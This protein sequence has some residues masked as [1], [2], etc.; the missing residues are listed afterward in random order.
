[1]LLRSVSAIGLCD[2]LVGNLLPPLRL[3]RGLLWRARR[4]C[5]SGGYRST[6]RPDM[7]QAP[8]LCSVIKK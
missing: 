7:R 1:M 6:M 8:V 4:G 3:L 5:M 2:V